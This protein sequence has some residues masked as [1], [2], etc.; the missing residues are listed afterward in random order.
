LASG[1]ELGQIGHAVNH[2]SKL[3]PCPGI[4]SAEKEALISRFKGLIEGIP[5][6]EKT[7]LLDLIRALKVT[8]Q[9]A[10]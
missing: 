6:V 1:R 8:E 3:L 5:L 7:M 4:M 2:I 10:E 9:P